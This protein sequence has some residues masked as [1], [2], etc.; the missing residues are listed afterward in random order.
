MSVICSEIEETDSIIVLT[1]FC[2][3]AAG[4]IGSAE[5]VYLIQ[6]STPSFAYEL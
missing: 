6:R 2:W 5:V 1:A 4:D 3:S